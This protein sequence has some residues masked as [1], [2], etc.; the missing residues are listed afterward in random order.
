MD[1]KKRTLKVVL[2]GGPCCGKTTIIKE[3]KKRGHNII[4]EA[5]REILAENVKISYEEIQKRIFKR[6]LEKEIDTSEKTS[7]L[8]FLD[9]GH[10]DGIAYCQIKLGYIPEPLKSF[11]F[12]NQYDLIFI[13]DLL[14]FKK[15]GLR[16]EKDETEAKMIHHAIISAYKSFG[17]QV[18]FIP[19]MPIEARIN[20][21]LKNISE[22]LNCLKGGE[23]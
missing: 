6:Q 4:D 1:D 14:P 16:I 5:A 20:Y 11:D 17:Y 2:A 13:L 21:L 10:I 3:L 8:V 19:V 15:D 12:R 18:K 7:G 23:E 9:R 22:C